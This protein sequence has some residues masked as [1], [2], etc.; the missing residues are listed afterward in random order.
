M[1]MSWLKRTSIFNN[2]I[3]AVIL[4]F[5][6]NFVKIT[7]A[8]TDSQLTNVSS[9]MPVMGRDQKL[10]DY[11]DVE[12]AFEFQVI[13]EPSFEQRLIDN[14]WS[15][16][17]S[18][19][20]M[21]FVTRRGDPKNKMLIYTVWM[22]N[23]SLLKKY[24]N[25]SKKNE[26]PVAE[27]I[28][29]WV[30]SSEMDNYGY[31]MRPAVINSIKW[32]ESGG[33]IFFIGKK[34]RLPDQVYSV[35]LSTKEVKQL[36]N[37]DNPILSFDLHEQNDKLVY[38]ERVPQVTDTEPGETVRIAETSRLWDVY[39]PACDKRGF[40]AAKSQIVVQKISSPVDRTT[41]L[42]NNSMWKSD[43]WISPDGHKAITLVWPPA[44]KRWDG[45]YIW[46]EA[47]EMAGGRPFEPQQSLYANTDAR[48]WYQF[49]LLDLMN[50]RY[51]PLLDAP[52]K[53]IASARWLDNERVILANT[54]LPPIDTSGFKD[55]SR[56]RWTY[57]IEYNT[58]DR[59][60]NIIYE[61]A[62]NWKQADNNIKHTDVLFLA[63]GAVAI[64]RTDKKDKEIAPVILRRIN[65]QWKL[66]GVSLTSKKKDRNYL[67]PVEEIQF[68][69]KEDLNTPPDLWAR[70]TR[71]G[72]EL[73]LTDLNPNIKEMA[74][75]RAIE[76]RWQHKNG[77]ERGGTLIFPVGYQKGA[78]YPLVIQLRGYHRG[79]FVVGGFERTSAPFAARPLAS[80]G[81]MVLV[82]SLIAD[83]ASDN[84]L[85]TILSLNRE[86]VDSAIDQL[87]KD[88][89]IDESRV[90]MTGWSASGVPT[91]DYMVSGKH[92][93]AAAVIADALSVSMAG[94]ANFFGLMP[95]SMTYVEAMLGGARPWGDRL[96]EWTQRNPAFQLDKVKTPLMLHHY[97]PGNVGSWWDVYTILRRQGKAVELAHYPSSDHSPTRP[98]QWLHAQQ[99]IVDWY[100]FWLSEEQDVSTKSEQVTRWQKLRDYHELALDEVC[101]RNCAATGVGANAGS[102]GQSI[103]N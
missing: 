82:M 50:G 29:D 77:L 14:K 40:H 86:G 103:S 73:K 6:A 52:A 99:S 81:I 94:Y 72:K 5:T 71:S 91:L 15:K 56:R 64:N 16:S 96:V 13:V 48:L 68:Y 101:E 95:P 53:N 32:S 38:V 28:V 89:L 98:D 21:V 3:R 36:T 85:E 10:S 35:D 88:G 44:N 102:Q 97:T 83:S 12:D 90:G 2:F 80:R 55:E 93:L 23:I 57:L 75:G 69:E 58:N 26:R 24:M 22:Y 100:T 67:N 8:G 62:G 78:R 74:L 31:I 20:K 33:K 54:Y 92:R 70:N 79:E 7:Y 25:N 30:V 1:C 60:Y 65:D 41:L 18:G 49:Y 17:R 59:N 46:S 66:D 61:I 9:V 37:S 87:S 27:K 42:E 11:F 19:D 45:I 34:D 43:I 4:I 76:Y 63:D 51:E 84:P 39:C 47:E